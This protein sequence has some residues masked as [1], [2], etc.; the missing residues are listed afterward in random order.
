MRIGTIY[1]ANDKS[2]FD[3]LN[4]K[5]VKNSDLREL[6]FSRGI[7]VSSSTSRKD[8]ALYFSS[9]FHDYHDYQKLA[10]I[11]GGTNSRDKNTS[12]R[13]K[14]T[15]AFSIFRNSALELKAK[16]EEEGAVVAISGGDGTRLDVEIKYI[17]VH[18]NKSEFR[19]TS[20]KI[21]NLSII[22][23]GDDYVVHY[24]K[25]EDVDNWIDELVGFAKEKTTE[26]IELDEIAL[27]PTFDSEK[28]TQFLKKIIDSIEGYK[29]F[30]VTDVYVSKGRIASDEEED[31]G[32][33]TEIR[34]DKASLRGSG[35]LESAELKLLEDSHE[36][37]VSR[38]IWKSKKIVSGKSDTSG[39][40][41]YEFEAQFVNA[42]ECK[43]FAYLAR[44]F[45]KNQ[46]D[47]N[48]SSSRYTFTSEDE[49]LLG[50][51]IENSARK[52][53]SK[54]LESLS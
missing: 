4:Q 3:A 6:F 2:M 19:Q 13:I 5:N 23:E 34:I 52:I 42:D 48:F 41:I 18:F 47:G 30:D 8:L 37:Y 28:K 40:D 9:L 49:L 25:N 53:L 32:V 35:V 46:G 17:K 51:L 12:L 29:L 45:Y 20:T 15:A 43:E 33:S 7:F 27:P 54:L 16:L 1:S 36:F 14:T 44:G 26:K 38:I 11:F 22:K 24:P 31:G 21:A 39:S 10:H 50:K